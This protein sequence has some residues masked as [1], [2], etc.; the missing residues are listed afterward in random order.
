[1]F[2]SRILKHTFVIE[3]RRFEHDIDEGMGLHYITHE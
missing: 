2:R 1:M 3:E